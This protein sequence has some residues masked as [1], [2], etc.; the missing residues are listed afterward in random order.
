VE[1]S[2]DGGRDWRPARLTGR[3]EAT[4]W[5]TWEADLPLPRPGR[6]TVRARATDRTGAMQPE[7]AATNPGGYGNNS[8]HAVSF[9]VVA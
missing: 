3:D 2:A 1:L 6:Y 4:A 5:R 9:D 7:S 8:I